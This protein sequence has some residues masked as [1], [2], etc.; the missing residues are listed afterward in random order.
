MNS[1]TYNKYPAYKDSGV[2]WLGEIPKQWEVK[3][4]KFLGNIFP[5]ISGKKG[6]DF[7]KEYSSGLK[8]FIPFTNICNNLKISNEHFQYVRVRKTETQ[9]RIKKYDILFLMSSETFEDIAKSSIYLGND[10]ELYLNSFCKGFRISK[11]FMNP[12]FVNYLFFSPTYRNNFSNSGRGFT[13][14]NL[15]Q[16]IIN[17]VYTLIPTLPEQTAIAAFLDDKTAKIDTAIAQNE[18]MI[19]LLK[20]RKQ[21]IIQNAVTGKIVWNGNAWAEPVEVKDSG[22]EWIGEIPEHWEVILNK[23][24]FTERKESG[25]D[26]LP[27]LS[28]SI[29]SA[30]SSGELDDEDNIR[31]KIKIEDKSN[32]KLVEINDIVFNMMRAWQGAIGAVRT[33]GMVSPAYV[34]AIPNSKIKASFFEYQYRTNAFIQQMN[35]FSKGI[36]DFRKRLYWDEFKQLNTILPPKEEQTKIVTYIETQS[37]KIDRAIAL[38]QTQIEKLKEYKTILIDNAVTGKIKVS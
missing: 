3:K 5:G 34:V 22:V 21:I 15:K 7:S 20:E 19:A 32:Y 26:G 16:E 1:V 12:E 30:V 37:A 28:V 9:N 14:I 10:E 25:K 29:H 17:D 33:K 6:D 31:G 27:L 13:R 23:I 4:L 8:P 35:R 36:T 24:L 18:R 11:N 2:E 38:Q